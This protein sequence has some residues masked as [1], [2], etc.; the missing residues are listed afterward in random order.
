[1]ANGTGSGEAG[2]AIDHDVFN[3]HDGVVDDEPDSCGEAAESHQIE[4]LPD[5]PQKE[6]GDGYGDGYDE[7]GDERGAPIAQE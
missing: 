4:A 5:D 3:D 2:I 7:S 6:N 1:M